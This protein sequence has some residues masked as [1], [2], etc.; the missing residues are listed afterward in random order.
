MRRGRSKRR[1]HST[2]Y[3]WWWLVTGFGFAGLLIGILAGIAVF[4][5]MHMFDVV[6]WYIS[7][8]GGVGIGGMC[9]TSYVMTMED[10]TAAKWQ[11]YH[12]YR[13]REK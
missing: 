4:L 13:V 10:I 12:I 8:M 11:K 6:P 5:F 1:R 2:R 7:L 9:G 3:E